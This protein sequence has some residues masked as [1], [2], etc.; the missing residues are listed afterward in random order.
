MK[1]LTIAIMT[2]VLFMAAPFINSAYAH[3]SSGSHSHESVTQQA[4]AERANQMLVSL[5]DKKKLP[6]SWRTVK[7]STVQQKW[8]Y[9]R[10]EWEAMYI[11]STVADKNKQRVFIFLTLQG[12]YVAA[13]HTG[14]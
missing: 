9:G 5:I 1:N 3:G 7:V 12:E 6:E 2:A 13:N 4:A 10:K 14:D 11:N 8:F